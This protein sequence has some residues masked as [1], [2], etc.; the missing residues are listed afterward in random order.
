MTVRLFK[1]GP[2]GYY[3]VIRNQM[4]LQVF[5]TLAYDFMWQLRRMLIGG[6]RASNTYAKELHDTSI[7]VIPRP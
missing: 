4:A 5:R 7:V 3:R 6:Y 2:R 1:T